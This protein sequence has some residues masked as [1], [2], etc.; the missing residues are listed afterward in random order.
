MASS[1]EP[2]RR[3]PP[4]RAVLAKRSTRAVNTWSCPTLSVISSMFTS[5]R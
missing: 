4:K 2:T 1:R 5:V 3:L